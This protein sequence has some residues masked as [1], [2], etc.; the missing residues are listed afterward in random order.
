M[1]HEAGN[2]S[3]FL[4]IVGLLIVLATLIRTWSAKYA[5]IP[6]VV[7]LMALGVGLRFAQGRWNLMGAQAEW[8]LD[9]L[10]K[11][12]V[13]ALLFRVG[14]RSD[15]A[16]LRR[17]LPRASGV[18]VS[19]VVVSAGLGFATVWALGWGVIPALFVGVA[20]SATS[21]SIS[22]GVWEEAKLMRSN[23]AELL[24]DVAELDDLS[25]V[26]LMLAVLAA[27]HQLLDDSP[28]SALTTAAAAMGWMLLKVAAFAASC[29]LFAK[30][31]EQH[32]ISFLVRTETPPDRVVTILAVGFIAA[33]IAGWLGFSVAVGALFAGM[34]FSGDRRAD[35]GDLIDPLYAFLTPFF[36]IEI[37]YVLDPAI[38]GSSAVLGVVLFVPAVVGKVVGAGLP[39][40][41]GSGL[42]SGIL[43]GLSMVP[44]AEIG[45]LVARGGNRLGEWAMPDVIYGAI[46]V[47]FG[48][49]A[50]LAP[51]V[52]AVL[53]KR[54]KSEVDDST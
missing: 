21:I 6:P 33:A 14:L 42:R 28:V 51:A 52:L 36:F 44:R 7:G 2:E 24:L 13:A 45:L 43:L 8:T 9:F 27:A 49:T 1:T 37:G 39:V 32:L 5:R 22:V 34:A 41:G 23:L 12:G 31:A 29:W 35:S 20:M 4:L 48:L 25:A 40:L 17:Q 18:W 30:Y 19:N 54:W 50:T 46:V 10:A 3:V 16:G 53:L 15:M 26:L 38:L 11:V 47:A